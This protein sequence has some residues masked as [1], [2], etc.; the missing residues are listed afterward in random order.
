MAFQDTIYQRF[1]F[2]SRPFSR[3]YLLRP[4]SPIAGILG[5]IAVEDDACFV[6]KIAAV[7]APGTGTHNLVQLVNVVQL[8]AKITCKTTNYREHRDY[9]MEN[10]RVRFLFTS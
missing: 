8:L 1:N 4:H 10:A 5:G 9:F 2:A 6:D 3:L 7:T